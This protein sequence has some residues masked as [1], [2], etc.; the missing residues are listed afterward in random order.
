MW[1]RRAFGVGR[2]HCLQQQR[3]IVIETRVLAIQL[4]SFF[5]RRCDKVVTTE[6]RGCLVIELPHGWIL[7]GESLPHTD[8]LGA[9]AGEEKGNLCHRRPH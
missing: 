3:S 6:C 8:R 5:K 7:L 9:L 1:S 2:R 4:V